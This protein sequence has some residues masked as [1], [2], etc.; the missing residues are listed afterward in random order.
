[1]GVR[2]KT[3]AEQDAENEAFRK[4]YEAEEQRKREAEKPGG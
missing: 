4:E 2:I 1:V 3:L